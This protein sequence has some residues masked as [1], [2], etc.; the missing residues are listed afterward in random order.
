MS[1]AG[2]PAVATSAA[3]AAPAPNAIASPASVAASAA[4]QAAATPPHEATLLAAFRQLPSVQLRYADAVGPL[5]SAA[6]ALKDATATR[7]RFTARCN[8]AAPA[9]ALPKS[10]ALN[11]VA[12]A[13]LPSVEGEPAFFAACHAAL[14]DIERE[15]TKKVYDALLAAKDKHIAHLKGLA[16]AHTFTITAAASFRAFTAEYAATVD[17][18][19]GFPIFPVTAAVQD[20]ERHLS[21]RTSESL[22]QAAEH[23]QAEKQN[24]DAAALADRQAQEEVLAGAHSGQTI[25]ALAN[26]AVDA[27]LLPLQQQLRQLQRQREHGAPLQHPRAAASTSDGSPTR[28]QHRADTQGDRGQSTRPTSRTPIGKRAHDRKHGAAPFVTTPRSFR[29]GTATSLRRPRQPND[30]RRPHG[31]PPSHQVPSPVTSAQFRVV[32]TPAASGDHRV[33]RGDDIIS[34]PKPKNGKG[35]DRRFQPRSAPPTTATPETT[36]TRFNVRAHANARK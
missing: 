28:V 23:A 20:F 13:R 16:N 24:A 4:V 33:H 29:G 10:I 12:R 2:A 25:T 22:L 1:V 32:R 36:Q 11:L 14:A 21:V 7:E 5:L 27:K 17:T 30:T 9:L 31:D 35:G 19:Y 8:R 26:R 18:S 3:A 6:K 34:S 15:A